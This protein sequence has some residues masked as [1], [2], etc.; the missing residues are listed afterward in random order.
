VGHARGRD[1]K[2]APTRPTALPL[3]SHLRQPRIAQRF[4]D[5]LPVPNLRTLAPTADLRRGNAATDGRQEQVQA[6][7][8]TS[9][10]SFLLFYQ[11]LNSHHRIQPLTSS[12]CLWYT[13]SLG[14]TSTTSP[15]TQWTLA[16]M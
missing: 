4:L 15:C 13:F 12:L 5:R 1:P 8:E 11:I 2:G 6:H 10:M 9:R 16:S 7:G 14:T 3:G